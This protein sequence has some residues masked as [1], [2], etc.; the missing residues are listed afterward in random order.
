MASDLMKRLAKNSKL[1]KTSVLSESEYYKEHNEHMFRTR[2]PMLN[3]ALSGR[4][5]GGMSPGI[6][7]LCG[8]SK[9]FKT[10]FMIEVASGFQKKHP[11]GVILFYDSEKGAPIKYFTERGIDMDRVLHTPIYNIEEL[12]FDSVNQ[13]KFLE[14]EKIPV[15]I[16]VDSIGMLP[17]TKEVQN[18]E[19]E[20]SAADMTRAREMNSLFRIWTPYIA[21]NNIPCVVINHG[22]VSMDG[23][24]TFTVSGGKKV[25]LAADDVF[26]IG[27]QQDG[28]ASDLKGFYFVLNIDKSREC[29]EK[30]KIFIHC[31][32]EHGMN[33]FSGL[34]EEAK[35]IGLCTIG[36]WCKLLD[37]KTGEMLNKSFRKQEIYDTQTEWFIE[38]MKYQPFIDHI[39]KKYCLSGV[40]ST[41]SE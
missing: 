24:G 4:A 9:S 33:P 1:S 23:K 16:M 20:N 35:E 37:F 32:F 11:D 17:S 7:M 25:Y 2:I 21:F 6:L 26:I 31:T 13:L 40:T 8:E 14:A 29:K 36:A 41:K 3:V 19:D 39:T 5:D 18:A 12:K 38:L 22:Y 15:M 10:G 30:T 28:V 27:R 34:L